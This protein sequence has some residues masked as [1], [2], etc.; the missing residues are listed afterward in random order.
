MPICSDAESAA[1]PGY[2][3]PAQMAELRKPTN[4][5]FDA[6]FVRLMSLHHA[7]QSRWQTRGGIRPSTHACV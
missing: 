4:T 2:L 7:G 1:M 5:E 3:T 6:V